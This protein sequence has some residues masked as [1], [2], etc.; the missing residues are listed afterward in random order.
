MTSH[1][2]LGNPRLES[3][4]TIEIE[5]EMIRASRG[6]MPANRRVFE[7]PRSKFVVEDA[8]AYMA[9]TDRKYDFILSEPSN[10][11]VSGV[12]G[13]FTVEFYQ[14]MK[15]QL[16]PGGILGQWLHLYEIDDDLVASVLAGVDRVFPA[17][18]VYFTSTADILVVATADSVLPAADW[19]VVTLPG[20]AEDLLRV[21]PLLPE[22]LAAMRVA[23]H[24]VLRP[25]LSSG[26]TPNSDFRPILD[27]GTERT[28]FEH[29]YAEG[30]LRLSDSPFDVAA[31]LEGKAR[32]WGT[33]TVSPASE[34]PRVNALALGT[35]IRRAARGDPELDRSLLDSTA[36]AEIRR[37]AVFDRFV[38]TGT[39][40]VDWVEWVREFLVVERGLHGG[41]A[42]TVD[43][44][45]YTGVLRFLESAGAPQGV[46]H[47]VSFAHGLSSW[48]FAEA[49]HAGAGLLEQEELDAGWIDAAELRDGLVV[50]AVLNGDAQLAARA[51]EILEPRLDEPLTLRDRLLRAVATGPG[52]ASFAPRALPA[53]WNP[54]SRSPAGAAPASRG[55][56]L[57]AARRD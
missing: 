25:Y 21:H 30:L 11:W 54:P 29:R 26:V 36:L 51:V 13:L 28:R 31:A 46:R 1:F 53:R 24:A 22:Q 37:R 14:R 9:A 32:S 38:A 57:P 48:D 40:P 43:D 8:R 19:S 10:P 15:R 33:A 27:L 12:S 35:A 3:L 47:T 4:E 44:V 18:D 49:A 42:G 16:A 2:L 39:A 5:P 50:A 41:T 20:L 34:L 56:A 23:G 17:Y 7:D 52:P 55:G 45:F 6:F